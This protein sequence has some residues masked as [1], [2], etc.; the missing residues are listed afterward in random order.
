[1]AAPQLYLGS[2]PPDLHTAR[3]RARAIIESLGYQILE[4]DVTSPCAQN[5]EFIRQRLAQSSGLVQL[6]GLSF[7][8]VAPV[9]SSSSSGG[10]PASAPQSLA[11]L[12]QSLAQHASIPCY[13][14]LLGES[15]PYDP[16]PVEPADVQ[17]LQFHRRSHISAQ[18]TGWEAVDDLDLLSRRLKFITYRLEES[19]LG[20]ES[21]APTAAAATTTTTVGPH[22]PQRSLPVGPLLKEPLPG[23]PSASPPRPS[24]RRLGAIIATAAGAGIVACL[25]FLIY[26]YWMQYGWM[27]YA[28]RTAPATD[29]PVA[30]PDAAVTAAPE[31][32][33]PPG[34]SALA[35]TIRFAPEGSVVHAYSL[36]RLG[37]LLASSGGNAR[38]CQPDSL[39]ATNPARVVHTL[40]AEFQIPV[41]SVND[42][43]YSSDFWNK[44]PTSL[45][46]QALHRALQLRIQGRHQEVIRQ[47]SETIP[48]LKSASPADLHGELLAWVIHGDAQMQLCDFSGAADSYSRAALLIDKEILPLAFCDVLDRAGHALRHASR[49]E[50]AHRFL[51]ESIRLREEHCGPEY[52]QLA[53]PLQDFAHAVEVMEGKDPAIQHLRRALAMHTL[54]LGREDPRTVECMLELADML[55][56]ISQSQE[57]I[58][59]LRDALHAEE[60]TWGPG[61]L[62]LGET[63]C[64]LSR[65]LG[66]DDDR[67]NA[68]CVDL[69]NRALSLLEHTALHSTT[70]IDH[71]GTLPH[72]RMLTVLAWAQHH[73]GRT[74]E[75]AETIRQAYDALC[76]LPFEPASGFQRSL[77]WQHVLSL[78]CMLPSGIPKERLQEKARAMVTFAMETTGHK[79]TNCLGALTVA[80]YVDFFKAN[81][82]GAIEYFTLA[83]ES[84]SSLYGPGH[85]AMLPPLSRILLQHEMSKSSLQ[86]MQP[87]ID[88]FLAN[89]EKRTASDTPTTAYYLLKASESLRLSGYQGDL[90]PILQKSV[91]IFKTHLGPDHKLTLEATQALHRA[92][93]R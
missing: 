5:P 27:Y 72:V 88:M 50:E 47:V 69:A 85:P 46:G 8:P 21:A 86:E 15:F 63:L 52:P 73:R 93:S 75:A 32:P 4:T 35:A 12:E 37:M 3:Q 40:A 49:W 79:H 64:R 60:Q 65:A 61:N 28:S 30:P 53:L 25:T 10:S 45:A 44:S 16:A 29:S 26:H 80:G 48:L 31:L 55:D 71:T 13:T 38:N 6:V 7:G 82:A 84:A 11:M 83:I 41:T 33:L 87:F 20:A 62:M 70:R 74:S 89:A 39:W 66:A 43:L 22:L 91:D 24:S 19:R 1:M 68:E 18:P 14:Y 67:T 51:R 81:P 77:Y 56:P 58:Q 76:I 90:S 36:E 59:L 23:T 54:H 57:S 78:A 92:Q 17:V 34:I 42:A 2:T 9:P